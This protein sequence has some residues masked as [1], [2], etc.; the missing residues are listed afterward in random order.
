MRAICHHLFHYWI[1]RVLVMEEDSKIASFLVTGLKQ[2]GFAV[3][4]ASEGEN[5]LAL[6]EAVSYDAA[7]LD[8][9]LPKLDGLSL[10]RQMRQHKIL[11]RPSQTSSLRWSRNQKRNNPTGLNS[12]ASPPTA[13]NGCQKSIGSSI[14]PR[15][16]TSTRTCTPRCCARTS[17]S[18]NRSPSGDGEKM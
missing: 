8:I 5:G 7:V 10:L 12:R 4:S 14:E 2:N 17:A 15:A 16:S 6:A 9:M 1:M 11:T 18:R 13:R 3:D